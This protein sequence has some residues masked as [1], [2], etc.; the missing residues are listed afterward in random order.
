MAPVI[1][2]GQEYYYCCEHLRPWPPA[3]PLKVASLDS[4]VA[5]L[6]AWD[7]TLTDTMLQKMEAEQ[8]R[9]VQQKQR[10]KEAEVRQ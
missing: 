1:L 2:S 7:I 4:V 9:R 10:H 5:I 8:Q 6:N 3:V